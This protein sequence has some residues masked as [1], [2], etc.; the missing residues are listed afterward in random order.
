MQSDNTFPN[1]N[2]PAHYLSNRETANM[3][4]VFRTPSG[5]S[6]D[7]QLMLTLASPLELSNF[8]L[9]VAFSS[10]VFLVLLCLAVQCWDSGHEWVGRS[11]QTDWQVVCPHNIC[12]P[13]KLVGW[14]C[15]SPVAARDDGL[16]PPQIILYFDYCLDVKRLDTNIIKTTFLNRITNCSFKQLCFIL[17]EQKRNF[18]FNS[19]Y[20]NTLTIDFMVFFPQKSE[21]SVHFLQSSLSLGLNEE[22]PEHPPSPFSVAL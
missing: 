3:A 5:V 10:S 2:K 13:L 15:H 17:P 20:K 14:S 16:I 22:H 1:Q 12:A 6:I 7:E 9:F 21:T 4:S 8:F 18:C 11:G 19:C